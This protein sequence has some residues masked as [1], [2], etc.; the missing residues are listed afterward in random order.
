[1]RLMISDAWRPCA[2][3]KVALT[4]ADKISD[5]EITLWVA[6]LKPTCQVYLKEAIYHHLKCLCGY[7][8]ETLGVQM[9]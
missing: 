9:W 8:S 7:K 1:M 6:T 5:G 2:E 3:N 4:R